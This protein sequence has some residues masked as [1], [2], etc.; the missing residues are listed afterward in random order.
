MSAQIELKGIRKA[1]DGQPVLKNMN[2]EVAQGEFITLLGPSGC[3]KTTT[4]R[5][6][7]GFEA[8]DEGQVI[9]NGRD[10]TAL[11]PH[12]R[13]VNTL[14]QQYSLFPHLNV[15]ENIAFGLRIKGLKEGEI[16]QEVQQMLKLVGLSGYEKRKPESLSGGQKQRVAMARALVLEPQVF[17]LD[18]PLGALD[19]K[20]RKE[21]QTELKRIQQELGITF[22]FVTHDQ[23]EALTLSDRIVVLNEGIIQQIG[24]PMDI[25]NEPSMILWRILSEN[26]TLSKALCIG[27]VKYLF[28]DIALN[29]WIPGSGRMSRWMWSSGRRMQNWSVPKRACC[30][31]G[32]FR[33]SLWAFIMKCRS[34]PQRKC[35]WHIRRF[36]RHPVMK[37]GSASFRSTFIL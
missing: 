11:P 31:D 13:P 29:A 5:I 24:T 15:Y 9:F 4:L 7:G 21:M 16:G 35:I 37:W 25:Y 3:G 26:P 20:L 8:P 17:L 22:V 19:L 33:A 30:A 18:E 27:T 10:I 6:I 36:G 12:L 14:F 32:C 2:L 28:Q 34:R 1:F 23:E